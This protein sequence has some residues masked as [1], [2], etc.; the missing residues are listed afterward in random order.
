[1]YDSHNWLVD[2]T[3]LFDMS[4]SNEGEVDVVGMPRSAQTNTS[5][6]NMF[7]ESDFSDS[8]GK[9]Q[10]NLKRPLDASNRAESHGSNISN[11]QKSSTSADCSYFP[12]KLCGK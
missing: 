6:I 5:E 4:P 10:N 12:C 1:M 8:A 11:I 7:G 2:S 3:N 9:S